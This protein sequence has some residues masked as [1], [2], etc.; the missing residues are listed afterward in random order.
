MRKPLF[1][2]PLLVL[3]LA[4]PAV[5]GLSTKTIRLVPDQ[6]WTPT[7]QP[8]RITGEVFATGAHAADLKASM[9][10]WLR[11]GFEELGYEISSDAPLELY[12]TIDYVDWGSRVRRLAFGFNNSGMGGAVIFRLNGEQVGK[13]KFSSKLRGGVG[14]GSTNAMGKEVG[15][16]LA[17]KLHNG[18][19]DEELHE[20]KLDN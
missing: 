6:D 8:I 5:A 13:F 11:T 20:R 12:Y 4:G 10:K 17:L 3:V 18:E 16:P 7:A 19:R 14:G 1:L 15:P 9:D 2:V